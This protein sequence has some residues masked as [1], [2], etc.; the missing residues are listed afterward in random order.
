MISP[1]TV[2]PRPVEAIW[3]GSRLRDLLRRDHPADRAIGETW[4]VFDDNLA[5]SGE[6]AGRAL[7][8]LAAAA[9][10]A[11]LG[12]RGAATGV[13]GFPLLLKFIDANATLSVQ[14]HPDDG[15]ARRHGPTSRG[16]AEAYLV[17]EARPGARLYY[18]L[19]GDLDTARLARAVAG[20]TLEQH[21]ASIEVQPGDVVYTPPGTIHALGA[22]LVVY[23]I[24]QASN[25]TYRLYDWG[26][27]DG[28]GRPRELH[29]EQS[30]AVTRF[31]QP[32]ARPI[33]PLAAPDARGVRH[34]RAASRHFAL[35]SLEA[36]GASELDGETFHLLTSLDGTAT[37]VGERF[38]SVAIEHGRTLIVP[39]AAGR[40]AYQPPP[41]GRILRSYIPDLAADIIEPLRQAGHADAAIA[42]LGETL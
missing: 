2:S 14:V 29:I 19:Q 10:R 32:A 5:E 17:L 30:L 8:E 40:Y 38:G 33:A 42:A 41:G 3:G 18:G 22:G 36:P 26:R 7:A 28:Q 39:A 6:H 34:I 12:R 4:D 16:K 11:L 1:L 15:Y 23:E 35:E 21:L 37:I 31:P 9:P 24:Q 27:V 13:A 20:G 25:L